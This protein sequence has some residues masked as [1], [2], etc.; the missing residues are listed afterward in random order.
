MDFPQEPNA[1]ERLPDI[2]NAP[3]T[4][5]EPENERD[6]VYYFDTVVFKVRN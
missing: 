4:E 1:S 3:I 2:P 6:S 5:S